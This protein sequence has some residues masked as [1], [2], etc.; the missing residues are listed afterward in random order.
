[1]YIWYEFLKPSVQTE[2]NKNRK[3]IF[4]IF[5]TICPFASFKIWNCLWKLFM[6]LGFT[7]F[8]DKNNVL[9]DVCHPFLQ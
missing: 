6:A 2:D 9:F 4:P 7:H 5:S 8:A 3:E 1:M